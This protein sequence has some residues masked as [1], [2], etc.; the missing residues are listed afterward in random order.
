[1][2][3]GVIAGDAKAKTIAAMHEAFKQ[4][5]Y[6]IDA[7]VKPAQTV[8]DI[9]GTGKDTAYVNQVMAEYDAAP[10]KQMEIIMTQKWLSSY[11]SHVDQYTDYRRTGFPVM[12]DPNNPVHAP[13]KTFQP[14][15]NGDPVNPSV[16]DAVPVQLSR[17]Y[18]L[19]LPWASDEL[20][21]NGKA[22]A[23]KAPS[24]YKVFWDK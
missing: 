16:Q 9:V 21:S 2:K 1:M 13:G 15:V 19:S 8:P 14:P 3:A 11:G 6:V 5:D 10:A 17:A 7:Y 12:F 20:N 22:P 24:T 18:P 23:Q 4:V